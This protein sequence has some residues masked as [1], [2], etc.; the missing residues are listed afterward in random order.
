MAVL[1]NWGT[2]PDWSPYDGPVIQQAITFD[3]ANTWHHN[4]YTGAWTFT[5]YDRSRLLAPAAWQAAPYLQDECSAFTLT[6]TTC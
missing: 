3:Q 5:P 6:P 1:S 2:Y 4:T